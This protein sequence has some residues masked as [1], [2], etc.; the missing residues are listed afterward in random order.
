MGPPSRS[1]MKYTPRELKTNVNVSPTSP[2]REV[3]VL[4]G[5]LLIIIIGIYLLLGLAVDLLAPRISPE[6]EK[7]LAPL[8]MQ[9][10]QAEETATASAA[11]V[12]SLVHTMQVRCA[13][14]LPYAFTIHIQKSDLVNALALPGG[15]IIVFTGLLKKVGSENELTFVLGHEMGH[16]AH[17]DHL[18]GL[19]RAMV[20]MTMAAFLLGPDSEV[21]QLLAGG[22]G[23]TEMSFSRKQETWAD[24]YGL[25][26]VNCMYG[27]VGGA[28]DFFEKISK[29]ADPGVFGHYFSSHP[30][31]NRRIAY[32]HDL[33]R[34]SGYKT[35]ECK[36][37]P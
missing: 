34:Q 12:Q 25:A 6:F 30:E 19:G 13:P 36:P 24:E 3:F 35:E 37:F 7:Q 21:S 11:Q 26:V 14:D 29:E 4:T 20:F 16:Y 8:F 23:L 32:L 18:R 31:N 2:L 33:S 15:H 28:A 9:S 22:L 10:I 27:H 17:R 5:G 1:K